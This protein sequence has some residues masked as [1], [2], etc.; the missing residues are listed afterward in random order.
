VP[1]SSSLTR[2]ALGAAAVAAVGALGAWAASGGGVFSPGGLHAGRAGGGELGG[3]AS[4]AEVS[5]CGACHAPPFGSRR[6]ADRCLDCHR[7]VRAELGDTTRLHGILP[8]AERCLFCHVEHEGPRAVLTEFS[9]EGFPHERLGFALAVHQ[10]TAGGRT[11]TCSDCHGRE[12]FRF[13]EAR[14]ESCHRD[15]QVAFV[16]SHVRDWGSTCRACHEGS[17]RF[18]AFRHDTVDFRLTGSHVETECA[19]CHTGVRTFAAFAGAPETCVGCHRGDDAH[20]GS[21]GTDCAACHNTGRWED[22]DFEHTFPLDHGG[23][24]VVACRTCHQDMPSFRTYTCY[25]CHEHAPARVREEHLDEGITDF[26]NCVECHPTG[27]E[28]EAE[29]RGGRRE[30]RGREGR[31][32]DGG[33]RGRGRGGRGA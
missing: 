9:G 7:E 16:A 21:Y 11:F 31:R 28:G 14:C 1:A 18:S 12:T 10:E 27:T 32:E 8:D 25:G 24:G 2:W 22:A 23:G 33:R 17:D 19:A 5:Q 26:R 30:D 6:M 3:V 29:R 20:R 4:H 15:Y 13:D